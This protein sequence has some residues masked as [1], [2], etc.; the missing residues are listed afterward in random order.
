[1]RPAYKLAPPPGR[2]RPRLVLST[3]YSPR[4]GQN[5]VASLD[6]WVD[7]HGRPHLASRVLPRDTITLGPAQVSR[8]VFATP[9][10]SNLLGLTNL[11]LR[12]LHKSSLD[13][14]SLGLPRL[15]FLPRGIVQIQ[16]LYKGAS[17]PGV[18]RI[19]G[20]TAFLNGRAA[21]G[22]SVAD[23]VRQALHEPPRTGLVRPSGPVVV[24]S[25]VELR[26]RVTNARREV[27]TITSPAG[28]QQAR[29]SI[30]ASSGVVSWVPSAAGVARVHLSV[31]GM[32]GSTVTDSAALRV[33]SRPPS[34]RL[35]KAPTR[36]VVGRRV[37]LSF[38]AGHALDELAQIS[39]REGTFTRR[40][41]IR[42]GTGLIEW[43]PSRVGRAIVHVRA[44]GR[45]GQTAEDTARLTV[46][47]ARPT[48]GPKVTLVQVPDGA[49][50]GRE[51]EIAFRV[52]GSRGAVARIAGDDRDGR[53]W[54][55]ARPTGRVAFAWTPTR[56]GRYRLIVSAHSRGGTMTQTVMQLT[57]ER[58]R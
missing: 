3:V 46:A 1:M 18:S 56:P 33:L 32:D 4:R 30:R 12:D 35:T 41:L 48:R 52:T 23:A 40:Y 25:R 27:M 22:L 34:I 49:T 45:Q 43:I 58:S 15:V 26:F 19:I 10:V 24:G 11:E 28:R 42:D 2:T 5:L 17:G 29:R 47:R 14:V 16:S 53:V 57:A 55:F 51:S 6:G 31:E 20:V 50:V 9:R 13:T 8:L 38:K 7:G 54:R 37:T 21:V 44:R 39:T 36:A